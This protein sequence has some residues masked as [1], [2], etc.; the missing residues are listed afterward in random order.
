MKPFSF[1]TAAR[2]AGRHALTVLTALILAGCSVAPTYERPDA[3]TPAAFK[4]ALPPE[5]AGQWKTAEPA[6]NVLRGAW[7]KVFGDP[8][9]D[10]LQTQAVAANQNLKAAAARL[11]QARA[12]ARSTRSGL[13]P[14]VTA[15]FGPTR[16]RA[17]PASQGLSDGDASSA[18]TLW[19]AQAGV[20]YEADLFG[21]VSS[22][23]EASTANAEQSEALLRSVQLALQ[24]DVAENY[25]NVRELDAQRQIYDKTLE[26]RRKT[27]DLI[28]R[29][30]NAGDISELDLAR[31]RAELSSA[32]S[33][34]LGID[35]RRA[36]A[37]HALAVLLG[38]APSEFTMAPNPLTRV[39]VAVPAGLPSALLERRPDIA[40]AERA[41]AAANARIG[42]ARAAF[43]P[44][45]DITG[46]LGYESAQLGNLFEW[47]SRTFLL[48]PL[49]GAILSLPI[50]DAGRRQADLDR[51]RAVYEEDV[52]NY[53]Q[54]VL[55]A[56]REVVDGLASLR[57]LGSQTQ[58]Q[59]EAVKASS[60]AA[61]LSHTQYDEGS[62]S[63]LDV[64]D[65]DRTVLTQQRVSVQLDGERARS[66][67]RLI[68]ALGGGWELPAAVATR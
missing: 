64:I 8:Y 24:A 26:L 3:P 33:E 66:T 28:E 61:R 65:S 41:M 35:R 29:R 62:I 42:A 17:S 52:A 57:I 10:E 15:N 5:Q 18:S 4:E 50:F 12:L 20:A 49:S 40:A 16:Q 56:F 48:G 58:A 45:L 21:R 37:E 13:F 46:Y 23:V 54:T 68:R 31:A 67:I 2:P 36:D 34:A 9:L 43:F 51:A 7:W 60:R 55:T 25:F 6:E 1:R 14:E 19:R 27:L 47:S 11:A 30:F 22:T 63:F 59:D 38:K 32:Q 44:R 39:N 53:R